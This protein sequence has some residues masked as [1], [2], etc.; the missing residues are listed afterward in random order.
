MTDH[1][2]KLEFIR[3]S[4]EGSRLQVKTISWDGHVPTD[5]WIDYEPI[6]ENASPTDIDAAMNK[7]LADKRY[8]SRCQ[9]CQ[10]LNPD[11]WMHDSK[12]CQSCAEQYLG[13]LY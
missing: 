5:T 2:I 8:F 4:P 3:F 11:G 10:T 1:E 9:K 12:I 7:A 13:I 6:D